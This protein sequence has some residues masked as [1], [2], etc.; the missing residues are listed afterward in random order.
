[1]SLS[2]WSGA[3]SRMKWPMPS[4]S[5]RRQSSERTSEIRPKRM[6]TCVRTHQHNPLRTLMPRF[7]VYKDAGGSWR[8]RLLSDNNR[9]VASSGEAFSSRSAARRAAARLKELAPTATLP[10]E[11]LNRAVRIRLAPGRR[12]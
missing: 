1:M 6:G 3:S 4:S 5:A 7:D 11:N 12:L 2:T 9:K 8:W 10:V